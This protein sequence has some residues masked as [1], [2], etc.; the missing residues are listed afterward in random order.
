[1]KQFHS[2]AVYLAANFGCLAFWLQNNIKVFACL[3]HIFT[4]FLAQR[5]SSHRQVAG[6]DHLARFVREGTQTQF[7]PPV[8]RSK[9]RTQF[10]LRFLFRHTF[11]GARTILGIPHCTLGRTLGP[12]RRY[13][14]KSNQGNARVFQTEAFVYSDRVLVNCWS[15]DVH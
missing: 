3:G 8:R 11:T 14:A 15:V 10:S 1:M 7:N 4:F 2:Y 13:C 9:D 6:V 12:D 5:A